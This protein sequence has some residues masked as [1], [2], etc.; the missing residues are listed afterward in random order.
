MK[1]ESV[2]EA[3]LRNPVEVTHLELQAVVEAAEAQD[4]AFFAAYATDSGDPPTAWEK[5]Q[6][7]SNSLNLAR[8]FFKRGED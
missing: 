8:T 4:P 6:I 1:R 7:V 5:I 3:W 2:L